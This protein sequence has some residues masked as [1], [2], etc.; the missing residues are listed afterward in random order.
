[1]QRRRLLIIIAA[2]EDDDERE[3]HVQN[4]RPRPRPRHRSC[5]VHSILQARLELGEFHTLVQEQMRD[6]VRFQAAFR[7]TVRQFNELLARVGPRI[8]RMDTNY[9]LAIPPAERLAICLR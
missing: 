5:W 4:P 3:Q 2:L 1:M 8:A 7:L 6:G 9:R